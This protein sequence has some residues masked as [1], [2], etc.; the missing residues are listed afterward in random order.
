MPSFSDRIGVTTPPLLQ[1]NVISHELRVALWNVLVSVVLPFTPPGVEPDHVTWERRARRLFE[2]LA[3][4]ADEAGD[5]SY[6]I[7]QIKDA[8]FHAPD[9][10]YKPYNFVDY[11]LR[12]ANS[13]C[14]NSN[15][16]VMFPE[17]LNTALE[18]HNS[19]Y[20]VLA[21]VLAPITSAAEMQS[22]QEAAALPGD[23]LRGV[24]EHISAAVRLLS[25]RP[26]PDYRNSIK[27]SISAVEALAKAITGKD[28]AMLPEA[29]EA[30]AKVSPMHPAL[31]QGY[32][33]LYGYT[34]DAHGIRHALSDEDSSA[35]FD[36]AKYMLVGCSAFVNYLA[37]RAEAAGLLK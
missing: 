31:K 3:I 4:P 2:G 32:V 11:C 24:R 34:S 14:P 9:G 17:A 5:Y 26:H 36:E 19:G 28:K 33:K 21:G 16:A 23:R 18:E 35:G 29:L 25:Q 13:V 6:T 15:Y 37:S 30:L 10:W 27:E 12:K 20:R 8:F 1:T 7:Q 22:V